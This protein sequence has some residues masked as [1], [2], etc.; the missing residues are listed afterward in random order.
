MGSTAQDAV[1]L[2]ELAE[3]EGDESVLAELDA[4]LASV[5]AELDRMEF[6]RMMSSETDRSSA[7]LQINAG[8]GGTESCDW[9]N[10]LLR[11][12]TRWAEKSGMSVSLIDVLPG[13][14]AGV[15]NV[16]LQ[17]DGPYAYGYLKAENGVH[18]LVRISPFDAAKRRHTSFASVFVVPEEDNEIAVDI[19][20]A[21]LRI[22]VYRASG[23][24]GQHV[25]RTESAVRI[26]HE[27]SGIVVSCQAERSQHKN[28]DKAMK[29]LAA[30]LADLERRKQRAAR[31]E[32]EA[33]KMG[34]AFGSQIRSYVLAPYR[35]V[36]D[37]RTSHESP[38][39]DLVLDG[40]LD[41]FIKA[42]LLADAD[43]AEA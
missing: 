5:E 30:R 25:N 43:Q 23:A 33:A 35:M 10:M 1:D 14:E 13:E 41:G 20:P 16:V 7:I 40:E 12:Y 19:N 32:L 27:P 21:D 3:M 26:T 31:E 37:H 9:A 24:G 22:D 34:I 36:K 18:R 11:M 39:T 42:W 17:I 8:A 2:A 4:S 29:V 38:Q 28:R 15:R 6:Q